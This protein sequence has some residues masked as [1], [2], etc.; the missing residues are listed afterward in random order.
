MKNR[1]VAT[2]TLLFSIGLEDLAD[3]EKQEKETKVKKSHYF[4]IL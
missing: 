3:T 1:K 4:Q 2:T